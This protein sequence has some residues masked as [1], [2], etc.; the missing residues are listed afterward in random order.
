[1]AD[2]KYCP[3]SPRLLKHLL[4]RDIQFR[5]PG[6]HLHLKW[7]KLPVIR[8]SALCHVAALQ[9]LM[10]KLVLS[11]DQPLFV[12]DDFSLLTQSMLCKRL[13]T[14]LRMMDLPLLGYGFHTFRRS[15][16]PIAYDVD[17]SLASIQMHGAWRSNSVWSYISDNTSQSLQ[18]PLALQ[19]IANSLL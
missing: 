2:F 6:I 8:D 11:P 3:P 18:V 17:I 5:H 4:H 13:A 7:V 10:N 9:A 19:T 1:M 16:A 14:F 12:L 15:G